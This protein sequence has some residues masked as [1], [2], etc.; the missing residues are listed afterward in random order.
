MVTHSMLNLDTCDRIL[1]LVPGGKVAYY[2]P[3]A[4][5][6]RYF[7]QTRW[8]VVFEEFE[9]Q[10]ERDWAAEFTRSGDHAR[11]VAGPLG[12]APGDRP[13]PASRAGSPAK[14]QAPPRRRGRVRRPAGIGGPLSCLL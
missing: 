5:G 10:P 2:G 12:L 3:P 1:V 11:Y 9:K 4:E 14:D 8:D 6:L 13:Q 7:G